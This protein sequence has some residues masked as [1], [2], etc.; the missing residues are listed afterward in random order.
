MRGQSLTDLHVHS[1]FGVEMQQPATTVSSFGEVSVVPT[2][3][4]PYDNQQQQCQLT[5]REVLS[6]CIDGSHLALCE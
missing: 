4:R 3:L 6:Q 2:V 5:A 1:L